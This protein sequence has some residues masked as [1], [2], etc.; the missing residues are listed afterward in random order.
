MKGMFGTEHRKLLIS[1][2]WVWSGVRGLGRA[3]VCAWRFNMSREINGI[4][5]SREDGMAAG[6]SDVSCLSR[7]IL[8]RLFLP[9]YWPKAR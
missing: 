1:L 7:G 3:G 8:K 2:G 6:R 5:G 9:V 4:G